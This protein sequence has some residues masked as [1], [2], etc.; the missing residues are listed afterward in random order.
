MTVAGVRWLVLLILVGLVAAACGDPPAAPVSDDLD[1]GQDGGSVDV[2]GS[3]AP[4]EGGV[5]G[6]V[7]IGYAGSPD[8]LNP[9][10]GVLE[11]AYFIYEMTYDTLITLDLNGAYQPELATGWEVSDD[12]RTWTVELVDDATFSDGEP[13]TADDV[14]FTLELYRDTEDFP[15]LSTYPD[16]FTD[17]EVV[18]D[19][20]LQITTEDPIGNFESRLVFAYILPEH[21]WSEVDDTVEFENAEMIGSGPFTLADYRQGE[22]VNLA[23][24]EDHWD[25]AP[26]VDEVIFQTIENADAR[27]Q[28]L[29][30]GDI[31][32]ITEFPK[33]AVATLE[34]NEDVKV[35]A[36]DPVSPELRDIIFNQID[37]ADCPEDAKCTGHP[38]LRDLAVRQALSKAVDKQQI[39]DVALLGYGTPGL[40][41]TP[42]GLGPWFADDVQGYAFDLDAA[43]QQLD[44]AGYVD[45]DGDGVRECLPEQDCKDLTFRFNFANDIDSAPREVELISGWWKQIGVATKVQ[46]LDPDTLTSVCCPGYDHDV[47]LW[48]W[49]S[50]PDPGYLLSAALTEE[51]GTGFSETGYS[52]PAYD[53]LFAQQAVETDPARREEMVHDLQRMLVEDAVLVVPYYQE[54]VQAYRTDTFTGW[55][56]S[57]PRLALADPTSLQVVRPVE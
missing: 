7:R 51:I 46:G 18:D 26:K 24:R 41:L 48:G 19:H 49:V 2:A 6:T 3:D 33:T 17:I 38:A 34:R 14:K 29:A 36:G 45:G 55:R 37:P 40:T 22:F 20:T 35:V 32:L 31:D 13:V 23:A 52:N 11:E 44:D 42:V 28:A 10:N 50:D 57:E 39:I 27:V 16:V 25:E 5:G 53:E 56:D 15:F 21:V 47:F 30:N 9:G 54:T 1:G 4:V 43:N 8:S 12:G